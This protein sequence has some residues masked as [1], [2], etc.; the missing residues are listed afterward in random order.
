M[1]L[2]PPLPLLL[3]LALWC[4]CSALLRPPLTL[5]SPFPPPACSL[6]PTSRGSRPARR[7]A[8]T[9]GLAASRARSCAGTPARRCRPPRPA[10]GGEGRTGPFWPTGSRT[11]ELPFPRSPSVFLLISS[12]PNSILPHFLWP[13]CHPLKTDF[14]PCSIAP[15]ERCGAISWS[16]P[17]LTTP[18]EHLSHQALC[19][20]STQHHPCCPNSRCSQDCR[21]PRDRRH[22]RRRGGAVRLAHKVC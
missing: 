6:S 10:A 5:P 12:L 16:L 22:D 15:S 9:S 18:L 21:R 13:A 14:I 8:R 19:L 11:P 20:P 3:E 1:V 7:A 17:C 2:P 4:A